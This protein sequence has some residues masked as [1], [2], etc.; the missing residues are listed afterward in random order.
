MLETNKIAKQIPINFLI[1]LIIATLL[2]VCFLSTIPNGLHHDEATSG[3]D[4]YSLLKTG[5]SQYGEFL[6]LFS[7]AFSDYNES[8]TR[9][10]TVPFVGVL[11]LNE[12]A[13]RLPMAIIGTITVF[14]VYY[15]AKELFNERIAL[16]S[17]LFLAISPWHIQFS[18]IAFIGLFLPFFFCLG[19]LFFFKSFQNPKYLS[20][21]AITFGLSLY[22]YNSARV[23]VPLFLLGL[24]Y[25]FRNYLLRVWKHTLIACI[26]FLPIFILLFSFW[27][28]P[29]GM[30][31]VRSL[32]GIVTNPFQI[33]INYLSY[34][35]PVFL[36]FIGDSNLRHSPPGI[37][38]LHFLELITVSVGIF[39]LLKEKSQQRDILLL[40]LL[41]YPIP[42]A[43]TAPEHALRSIVGAPL[44]SIFSG[45]G[46]SRL[47]DIF[48]D[49]K[50]IFS[51]L[52]IFLLA[53]SIT[54]YVNCYF[55]D[56]PKYST[57]KTWRYGM[58]EAITY[59]EN[60]SDSC[61][62]VSNQFHY[63]NIFILFYTQY[64]PA[65]YQ[66]LPIEP[67]LAAQGSS[68]YSLG[69]YRIAPISRQLVVNDRCLL[70]IKP[71]EIKEIVAGG[72]D[73]Q[74]MHTIRNPRGEEEIRL[75]E[76][77]SRTLGDNASL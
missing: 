53:A 57:H 49:R 19:L 39:F 33:I 1:V 12:F 76:V 34:F 48:K 23:F 60:S 2:R 26:L 45:Y 71:D 54:W 37:G 40:W 61:V 77:L 63:M 25:R 21:S 18:R 17:A 52:T 29:E 43:L 51:F 73:W 56:Y 16:F 11:G 65:L 67:S 9:L 59:A 55:V 72:Y 58:K 7:K 28:S 50:K 66:R 3:Y 68:G 41:L 36:F 8:L 32:G 62:I 30:T 47:A 6:P 70:V 75:I 15:L 14:I 69:K 42:A 10:I 22:T 13:I 4:S 24:V 31:R 38:E 44:F 74:E 20:L 46:L 64:E 35:T 5:H 27:T